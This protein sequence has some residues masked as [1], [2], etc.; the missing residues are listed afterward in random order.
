MLC[1]TILTLV[2]FRAFLRRSVFGA[3]TA[4]YTLTADALFEGRMQQ[5]QQLFV[6]QAVRRHT[7]R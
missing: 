3:V 7:A 2:S 4:A 5:H 1:P 6:D